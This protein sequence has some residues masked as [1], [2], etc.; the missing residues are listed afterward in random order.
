MPVDGTA[1]ATFKYVPPYSGRGSI[2][3]KFFSKELNDVDGFLAFEI[4]PRPS[5]IYM[6]GNNRPRSYIV[7]TDVIP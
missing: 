5:D 3:A 1:S 4:E 7:R 6:H 2:V